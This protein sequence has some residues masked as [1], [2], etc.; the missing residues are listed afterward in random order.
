M[1]PPRR[2]VTLLDQ[3]RL[4]QI[5]QCIYHNA[6]LTPQH[7]SLYA[8]HTCDTDLF[9]RI[10]TTVLQVHTDEVWSLEWSHSGK[11]LASASKDKSVIVW[12]VGVSIFEPSASPAYSNA[13]L[14]MSQPNS[15]PDISLH[16]HLQDHQFPVGCLAW[17]LDDTILLSSCEQLI[18]MWNTEVRQVPCSQSSRRLNPSLVGCAHPNDRGPYGACLSAGLGARWVRVHF[19]LPRSKDQLMGKAL[20]LA[21]Y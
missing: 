12:S 4:H 2:F 11:F 6:P 1:I 17:S 16:L 5:S 15:N 14:Y 13:E 9:P 3:A 8:D 20:S 19:G 21:R 10:T 18:K 7:F